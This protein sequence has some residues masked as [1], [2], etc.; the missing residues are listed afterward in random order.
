MAKYYTRVRISRMSELLDLS[1]DVSVSINT[2][3]PN[4]IVR[5]KAMS[6]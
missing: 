3:S 1:T 4:H 2:P 6:N 5:S